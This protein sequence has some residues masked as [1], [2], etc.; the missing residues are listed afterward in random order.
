MG[1]SQRLIEQLKDEIANQQASLVKEHA[2]FQR[3]EKEKDV[4]K[5][6]L[7]RLKKEAKEAERYAAEQQE[8][9]GKLQ[10]LIQEG[11]S[12]RTR[13]KKELNQVSMLF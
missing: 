9:H 4:L 5:A 11:D 12:E 13:Q 2:N 7:A 6:E 10:K 3:I 8:E 1:I